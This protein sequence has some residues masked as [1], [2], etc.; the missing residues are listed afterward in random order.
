[1]ID[2]AQGNVFRTTLVCVDDSQDGRFT[3]RLYNT[4]RQEGLRF[5]GVLEFLSQMEEL[6]DSMKLPQSFTTK[7]SFSPMEAL[8]PMMSGAE[9]CP[10][11]EATFL[12]RVLFRQ[13]ASWQGSVTW[14]EAKAETPFRSALELLLMMRSALAGG[15]TAQ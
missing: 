15:E 9:Q 6:L 11:Q 1:M 10:G 14:V 12:L 2:R 5:Q 7:R 3:G 4:Y 8:E 13:N